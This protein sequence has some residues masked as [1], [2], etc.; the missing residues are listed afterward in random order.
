MSTHYQTVRNGEGLP[1]SPAVLPK[2]PTYR[3][4][5]IVSVHGQ[6]GHE[7]PLAGSGGANKKFPSG[8]VFPPAGDVFVASLFK[9]GSPGLA[10]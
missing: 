7:G 4:T 10:V 8:V 3:Q 1:Q 9:C 6:A 5:C 2:G